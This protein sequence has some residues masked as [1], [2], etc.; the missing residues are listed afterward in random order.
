MSGLKTLYIEDD[1]RAA[2][3]VR[4]LADQSDIAL[5]WAAS[6]QE[7]LKLAGVE[8]FDVIILDRMLPDLDGLTILSRLRESG[9]GTPV[10]MLSAL[11]R[12]TDRAEGLDGGADDYLAKP[13]EAE[14]L[15]A[16]LRALHRR[17]SGR[18]HSAVIL[19]GAFECHVKARTAFRDNRHLALSPKEFEL[20]RYFMENAGEILTR[21][22]LLRDVWKMNF[23][24]QTNVVDVN[25][26]RLRRK[27]EDGFD[28]PALETIWG[29]GYRL[30]DGR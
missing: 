29:S 6:G 25:I 10:L 21:E 11:G 7:G 30:L 18:E 16:R 24:P 23:D 20:F 9:I 22:M 4:E 13:F 3:Q 26:G 5:V 1:A 12:T 2:Q 17:A 8:R 19:Y 28:L 14:E 27:L 15:L